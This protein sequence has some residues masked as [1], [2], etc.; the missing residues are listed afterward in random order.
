MLLPECG[1]LVF[2]PRLVCDSSPPCLPPHAVARFPVHAYP[3]SSCS[4]LHAA[5][6]AS[7]RPAS[8]SFN[9]RRFLLPRL[10]PQ[11]L[12]AS[13]LHQLPL[14]RFP[15][16]WRR[17]SRAPFEGG[18]AVLRRLGCH[19]DLPACYFCSWTTTLTRH[20]LRTMTRERFASREACAAPTHRAPDGWRRARVP[21][22][23][24]R[25]EG[26]RPVPLPAQTPAL[27]SLAR[28]R[29]LLGGERLWLCPL[30][31]VAGWARRFGL[32]RR[33]PPRPEVGP[34]LCP[35]FV[36]EFKVAV[37]CRARARVGSA[38]TPPV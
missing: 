12:P 22:P 26:A 5:V 15:L 16:A 30:L 36:G 9:S 37:P 28:D 1:S 10:P 25:R 24:S 27:G 4:L 32:V 33:A 23:C 21:L 20:S 31:A 18:L 2:F 14:A 17:V 8:S 19:Q 6:A 34:A 29:E 3:P 38:R 13:C 35:R 11:A 7:G